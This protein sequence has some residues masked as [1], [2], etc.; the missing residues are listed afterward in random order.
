[1]TSSTTDQQ[2]S[3]AICE[4]LFASSLHLG[5]VPGGAC[6]DVPELKWAF[7][8]RLML[9]RILAARFNAEETPVRVAQLTEMVRTRQVPASWLTDPASPDN[10]ASELANQGWTP[11]PAWAGMALQLQTSL[12]ELPLPAGLTVTRVTD[13]ETLRVATGIYTS[14]A[15]P[16]Y[17]SAFAD[18]FC[19]LGCGSHLP[20]SYYLALLHG[21][22]VACSML[23]CGAGAAGLYFIATLPDF[24]RQGIG[25]A[26]TRHT[27]QQAQQLG[28]SLIILQATELGERIYR[29][30]GFEEYCRIGCYLLKP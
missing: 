18:I 24:R 5:Q 20:W 11:T 15:P 16:E 9:N 29:P 21:E 30:L 4:N 13:T 2:L 19:D 27:I 1:M 7:T 26:I 28:H 6:S 23:Y 12:P 10:L 17:Q 3:T 8:G 22:P 25:T 14:Q